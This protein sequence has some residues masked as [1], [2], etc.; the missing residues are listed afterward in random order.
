MR[1]KHIK[2][3]GF[4][5]FVD[6]TTVPFPS[7]LTAVV[8]P[9]GCGKSNIIDAVRWVMGESSA[10]QLRGESLDDVIF[11]GS[12]NRK[13]LGQASIELNFDNSDGSLGGQYASYAEIAIR[14]EITRDGQ[15]NYFLNGTR[16][17]RRDITDLFLGTGLGPRSYAIIEQGT[18]SRVVEAKPDEL[19]SYLEEVAGISRY[20]E[21]RHETELRIKHTQENLARLNDVCDEITRQ[22]NHLQR[23]ANAAERYQVLKQEERLLKA[24]IQ[25]LRWRQLNEQLAVHTENLQA[26]EAALAEAHT[27]QQTI[28]VSLE[29]QRSEQSSASAHRNTIQARYYELGGEISRLEQTIQHQRERRE[30]VQAELAE[31]TRNWQATQDELTTTQQQHEQFAVEV[32][33][34]E[35]QLQQAK[36]AAEQ[37][38]HT[39]V[40]SE[41]TL[42]EWQTQW[43]NFNREASHTAQ[44]VQVEQTRI[45]HLEQRLQLTQQRITRLEQEHQ[46]I[47]DAPIPTDDLEQALLAMQAQHAEGEQ[48]LQNQVQQI[49]VQREHN[50]QIVGELDTAKSQLQT[51]RGHHG[52]LEALQ[53]AAFA[54]QQGVVTEWLNKRQLADKPRLA[55]LLQ[56]EPGWETAVETILAP[57]LQ[58][59]CVDNLQALNASLAELPQGNLSLVAQST[60]APAPELAQRSVTLLSKVQ[61]P[62][63]L[64]GLLAGVYVA[65]TLTEALDLAAQLSAQESVVTRTGVWLGNGW[66]RVS[67]EVDAKTGIL[68]RKRELTELAEALKIAEQ[69]TGELQTAVTAGQQQLADF[70]HARNEK[71]RDQVELIAKQADLRA[72]QHV[73]QARV[74]Q[75]E[76]RAQQISTELQD[77]ATQLST[78]QASLTQTRAHLQQ[79]QQII[80]QHAAQRETLLQSKTSYQT[81][82]DAARQQARSDQNAAHQFAL[83]LQAAKLQLDTTQQNHSRLQQQ[84]QDLQQRQQFLQQT[85]TD[86]AD[87]IAELAQQLQE[88]SELRVNVENEL[89]AARSQVEQLERAIQQLEKQRHAAEENIDTIRSQLEQARLTAQELQVRSKTVQ[90]QI[91]ESGYDLQAL[92]EQLPEEI[93]A[94]EWEEQLAQVTRKIER[95]G[96]INLAA[97]D[98]F[99]ALNERK[100]YLDAQHADLTEA[101]T[102]LEGA[103]HK[104]DRE[105]RSLFKDTFDKVNEHFKTLFPTL[106]GGG[107]AGLELLGDDLLEAGVAV[108]AQPPGKRNST[109]H[110]LSGGEKALTAIAL[111]FALFQL[112]PAPFC[113]LDEVD[114]PLDDANVGRFCNLVEQMSAKV[115]FIFISHNK[116]AIEMAQHLAGV[117]MHEAGVSRMVA[118]DVEKAIEL[119]AA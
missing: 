45:Q 119:A 110:L 32:T 1:L 72:R 86:N 76:Q 35:P 57:Y 112:C 50:K 14:R 28:E 83:R 34:L 70:E 64:T 25:T 53:K 90:E 108:M 71:Q 111:V 17:R 106:F 5:S 46:T 107:N 54:Q 87:P 9:N 15:S 63:P 51:L 99:N 97:I 104:M 81:A 11:N 4:K 29:Q 118:V 7:N 42:R 52:S 73:R 98:E 102:T 43:D 26:Q 47:Q 69:K 33:T 77:C 89:T 39:L 8:G 84:L 116:L 95:L 6:P 24:Q 61:A 94:T 105:T 79:A 44:Q 10:K 2:L 78:D 41:K 65:E 62:V 80:E 55:H 66:L 92:L 23:Q 37:S 113:M 93:I 88:F 27:A 109:I 49:A 58:A 115:Q 19:R 38:Q 3:A 100:T 40:E 36:Q 114:A 16:C 30:Q 103:M 22:L 117:T 91:T 21:R 31:I 85:L 74:T 101:L 75:L 96:A 12:T 67:K 59:I 82:L 56:V 18:I 13:P 20:K 60:L 48:Q 68:Q